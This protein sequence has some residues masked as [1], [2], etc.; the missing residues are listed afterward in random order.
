MDILRL[1][2][3]IIGINYG[4]N[5]VIQNLCCVEKACMGKERKVCLSGYAKIDQVVVVKKWESELP[6]NRL[7][8]RT[9]VKCIDCVKDCVGKPGA[10]IN[11]DC[12]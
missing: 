1:A 7:R 4:R 10:D 8:G 6:C 9:R 12:A 3:D 11:K 5:K 2:Y